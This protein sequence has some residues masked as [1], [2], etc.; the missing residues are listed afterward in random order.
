VR[1]ASEAHGQLVSNIQSIFMKPTDF[2]PH[3]WQ[4]EAHG[5]LRFSLNR[6][7]PSNVFYL[8]LARQFTPVGD[9]KKLAPSINRSG[10]P[11]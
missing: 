2:S 8:P 1:N 10:C 6:I 5:D 7:A 9:I 3:F 4:P 11:N